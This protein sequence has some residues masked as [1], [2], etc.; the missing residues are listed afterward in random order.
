MILAIDIGSNTIKCL[1]GYAENGVV[2]RVFEKSL[3]NRI[4]DNGGVLVENASQM[5]A[6]SIVDFK[7]S[8]KEFCDEFQV[9]VVATSALRDSNEREKIVQDVYVREMVDY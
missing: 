2:V 1:L 4:L 6:D 7:A 8:A 3:E 9:K 5:I